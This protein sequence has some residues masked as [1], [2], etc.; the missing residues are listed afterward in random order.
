MFFESEFCFYE[1]IAHDEVIG[2]ID[3][4]AG[5]KA[6]VPK[7]MERDFGKRSEFSLF[8]FGDF[9]FR[10]EKEKDTEHEHSKE[11]TE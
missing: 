7:G 4:K 6:A 5:G 2:I 9:F 3:I 1:F 10:D 8:G 11:D